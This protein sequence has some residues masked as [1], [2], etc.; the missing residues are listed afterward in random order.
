MLI[1]E[2]K[3]NPAAALGQAGW[4]EPVEAEASGGTA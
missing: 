1:V 4:Q 3:E 2:Q